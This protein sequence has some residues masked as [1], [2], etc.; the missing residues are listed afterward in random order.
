MKFESKFKYFHYKNAFCRYKIV[1]ILSQPQCDKICAVDPQKHAWESQFV[2]Y[3]CP[4]ASEASLTNM[5]KS[6]T[7]IT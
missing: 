5:G 3:G 4:S 2:E 7:C 1:A 6:H